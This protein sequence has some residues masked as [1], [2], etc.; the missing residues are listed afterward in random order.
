MEFFKWYNES[1]P[2]FAY[3][4]QIIREVDTTMTRYEIIY[5]RRKDHI[6]SKSSTWDEWGEQITWPILKSTDIHKLI[7]DI[8][9][10]RWK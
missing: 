10:W 1:S 9:T 5:F 7:S 2:G 4:K 6:W 8:F 3:G